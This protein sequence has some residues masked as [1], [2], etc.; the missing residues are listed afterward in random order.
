MI[1]YVDEFGV[2]S[3]TPPDPEE[4]EEIEA[5]DIVL[6]IPPKEEGDAVIGKTGRVDFFDTNKGFGFINEIGGPGR[7][8]VHV[9]NML[10]EIH[11]G[12]TVTFELEKTPKG[13]NAI[14]VKKS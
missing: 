13:L 9:T 14:Q 1:A 6:G 3:D 7:Y 11:E 4:R 5:S 12:D 8:F 2:I 10:E